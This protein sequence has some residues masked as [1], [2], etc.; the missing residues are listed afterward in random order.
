MSNISSPNTTNNYSPNLALSTNN[1]NLQQQQSQQQTI[2][3]TTGTQQQPSATANMS[4]TAQLGTNYPCYGGVSPTEGS[5]ASDTSSNNGSTTIS[6]QA[7][8]NRSRAQSG[9][10]A[11]VAATATIPPNDEDQFSG[12]C[13][14]TSFASPNTSSVMNNTTPLSANS[15]NQVD[16]KLNF[17]LNNPYN[18]NMLTNQQQQFW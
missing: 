7:A 17:N 3:Q 13:P 6:G 1:N 18:N 2:P 12:I 14:S 16:M 11:P 10:T 15:Y 5:T 8:S 4:A 9:P